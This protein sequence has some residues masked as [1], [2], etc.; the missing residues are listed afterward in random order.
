[1]KKRTRKALKFLKEHK[2]ARVFSIA[3][4]S[5]LSVFFL[6]NFGRYIKD[7]IN[8]YITR[9][10]RFY[11]NSDRLT[12]DNKKYEI[13]FWTGNSDYEI[14]INVDSLDN[15]LRGAEMDLVYYIE[16]EADAGMQCI[17]NRNSGTISNLTNKDSFTVTAHPTRV[18]AEGESASIRIKARVEE[19]FQKELSGEFTFV[20]G[21]YKMNYKIEDKVSQPY[22][23]SVISNTLND[24]IVIYPFDGYN[25]GDPITEE[26]YNL[27]SDDNKKKCASAII[28]LSFDPTVVRLDMTNYYY[29]HRL[30]QEIQTI[31]GYDYVNKF[32]FAINPKTSVAI[33][34]YKLNTNADYTYPITNSNQVVEFEAR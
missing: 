11:F 1:M 13:N 7:I 24:H 25:Q 2:K 22:L 20:V 30:S 28:T 4:I 12:V 5:V 9:T 16:C 8:N 6:I 23:T 26:Q 27:L 33:K 15:A 10:Q 31:D 29:Q 17:L 19:P 3:F 21:K 18:F 32:T 34:F 14:G